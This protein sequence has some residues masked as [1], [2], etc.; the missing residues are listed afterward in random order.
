MAN[1][2]NIVITVMDVSHGNNSMLL[3]SENKGEFQIAV[4]SEISMKGNVQEVEEKLKGV[5]MVKEDLV[6]VLCH[7]FK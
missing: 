2:H 4:F 3:R 5:R 1:L 7:R 6:E